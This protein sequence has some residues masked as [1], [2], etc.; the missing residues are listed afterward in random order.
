MSKVAEK[1]VATLLSAKNGLTYL[2]VNDWTLVADK[3]NRVHFKKGDVLVKKGLAPNG[4]Y[5]LLKGTAKVQLL[6]LPIRTIG[7]GEICG[8][9]SFLEDE[10][11]SASVI[12]DENVEA[13]HLDR[14][15]LQSLFELFPHL[16][17]RF[18][19][20]LATNLSRRLRDMIA[21]AGA[22]TSSASRK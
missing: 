7:R 21:A 20:S 18:Y 3:A 14:P 17:S 10:A 2:T 16:G 4:I 9:M 1:E 12:A 13:Y 6:S 5:F 8:E 19:R 22:E 15:T 11:A